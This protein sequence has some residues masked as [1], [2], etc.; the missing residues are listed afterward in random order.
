MTHNLGAEVT[1]HGKDLEK[2]GQSQGDL[3]KKKKKS[4]LFSAS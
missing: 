4:E 1:W 2:Q 3:K